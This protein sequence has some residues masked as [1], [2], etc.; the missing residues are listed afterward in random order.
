MDLYKEFQN[1]DCRRFE[2]EVFENNSHDPFRQR[3]ANIRSWRDIREYFGLSPMHC[4]EHQLREGFMSKKLHEALE[5][6]LGAE[7]LAAY[8]GDGSEPKK[9]KEQQQEDDLVT[10][11]F[12][13]VNDYSRLRLHRLGKGDR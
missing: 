9:S 6:K 12:G 11:M 4:D 3:L 1:F 7:R 8:F 2:D 5:N 13:A 10:M